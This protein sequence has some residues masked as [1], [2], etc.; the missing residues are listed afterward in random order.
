MKQSRKIGDRECLI[1]Q[2]GEVP[3]VLLIQP[4]GVHEQDSI[5]SEMA[6]VAQGAD[7]ELVMVAFTVTNWELELTPW[8]DA[9]VS[10]N[11]AVGE[12]ATETLRYVISELIPA[13]V[14]DYG[15][16]PIVLGGYS[17]AGLFALWASK[18]STVFSAV[19][20]VSPSV[21]IGGWCDFA[22]RH[23]V[24]AASV[25]LSL[26]DREERTRNKAFARV[27][28][29]IR[30]EHELLQ[31]QLG[32]SHCMLEWNPGNHFADNALR[33]AKGFLWCLKQVDVR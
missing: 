17:L 6:I 31:Q 18:E 23:P 30:F 12:H 5:D 25:Y 19:A 4:L 22:L 7:T 33:T 32:S 28:A 21:W 15:Q 24:G 2:V 8:H 27:G 11:P 16:L 13:L 29:N 10:R 3:R 14:A 1:Y 20:A 9:A 26:G